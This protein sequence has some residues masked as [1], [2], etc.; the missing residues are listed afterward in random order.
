MNGWKTPAK[1][2]LST[3]FP[4]IRELY[5]KITGDNNRPNNDQMIDSILDKIKTPQDLLKK[6]EITV[7]ILRFPLSFSPVIHELGLISN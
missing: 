1:Q 7:S 4:D 6:Q 5:K 3:S 2:F